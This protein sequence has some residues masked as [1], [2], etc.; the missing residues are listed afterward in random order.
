[1]KPCRYT[2]KN[3]ITYFHYNTK[4]LFRFVR[5]GNEFGDV[6]FI[7]TQRKGNILTYRGF[8]T[9]ENPCKVIQTIDIQ[10]LNSFDGEIPSDDDYVNPPQNRKKSL[11]SVSFEIIDFKSY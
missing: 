8:G 9:Y 6:G 3:G 2:I 5:L 11:V 7:L 4:D 1:M 10:W